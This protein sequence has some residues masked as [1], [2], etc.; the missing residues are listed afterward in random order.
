MANYP[1]PLPSEA[2]DIPGHG[3]GREPFEPPRVWKGVATLAAMFALVGAV[4]GAGVL[5]SDNLHAMPISSSA[6][7]TAPAAGPSPAPS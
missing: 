2:A 7:A 1:T 4:I 5:E 6:T 3:L